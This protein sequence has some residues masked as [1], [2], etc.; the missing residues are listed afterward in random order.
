MKKTF[1]GMTVGAIALAC[2]FTS[3]TGAHAADS[4]YGKKYK[5]CKNYVKVWRSGGKVYAYAKQTCNRQ[6]L[7]LRPTVALS[8]NGGRDG[9]TDAGKACKFAKSC[10][11]KKVSLKAKRGKIYRASNSGTATLGRPSDQ[12]MF[13]PASTVAHATYKAR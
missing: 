6:A 9:W 12:D 13:W 8:A 3:G 10:K 11:T 1:K 5:G 2:I 4:D 7:A